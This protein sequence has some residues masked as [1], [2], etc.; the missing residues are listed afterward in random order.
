MSRAVKAFSAGKIEAPIT[1]DGKTQTVSATYNVNVTVVSTG[2][3]F[4]THV[5]VLD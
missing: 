2:H 5:D 1:V 4:Q 3:L